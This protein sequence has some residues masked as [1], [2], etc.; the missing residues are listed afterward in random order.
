MRDCLCVK[1]FKACHALET[2]LALSH[3]RILFLSY[4]G[5]DLLSEGP[6]L[7]SNA[8]VDADLATHIA[9]GRIRANM[10]GRDCSNWLSSAV[11]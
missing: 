4:P 10:T 7:G 2:S 6:V 9:A 8:L 5:S 3:S 11:C 1:I